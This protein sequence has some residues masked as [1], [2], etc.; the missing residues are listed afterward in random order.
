MILTDTGL[1]FISI[2]LVKKIG[3]TPQFTFEFNQRESYFEGKAVKGAFEYDIGK[4]ILLLN[5]SNNIKFIN[6]Q[7]LQEDKVI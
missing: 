3:R 2:N 5:G 4:I 7:K 6:R 1:Y